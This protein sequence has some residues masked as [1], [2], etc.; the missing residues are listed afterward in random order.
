MSAAGREGGR[1]K[2]GVQRE[3][4]GK[5]RSSQ[6][7]SCARMTVLIISPTCTLKGPLNRP[8]SPGDP[9]LPHTCPASHPQRMQDPESGMVREGNREFAASP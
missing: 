1:G 5:G 8:V 4:G 9:A 3:L 7:D 6:P 2:S